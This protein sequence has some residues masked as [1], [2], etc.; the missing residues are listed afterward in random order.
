MIDPLLP[1]QYLRRAG[2][3]LVEPRKRLMLAVLKTALDDYRRVTSD[4]G[5]A[6]PKAQRDAIAWVESTD[7]SWPFSFENLC[8]GVGLDP[9]WLRRGLGQPHSVETASAM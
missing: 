9:T 8:E 3:R 7:R 6:D 4:G 5:I 2:E 1:D